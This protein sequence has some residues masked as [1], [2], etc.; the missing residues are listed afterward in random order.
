MTDVASFGG[1]VTIER[2]MYLCDIG[3]KPIDDITTQMI[4]CT[5]SWSAG[6]DGGTSM[7]VDFTM[8]ERLS[9]LAAQNTFVSPEITYR[10]GDGTVRRS[11]LGVYL[12]MLPRKTISTGGVV[13][14]Y[15][16]KDLTWIL[17]NS[18]LTKAQSFPAGTNFGEAIA[19]IC[20][21][22][23]LTNLD[24][25]LTSRTMGAARTFRRGQRRRG[26]ANAL[27]KAISWYNLY[28][29]LDGAMTTL[30][31]RDWSQTAPI[32]IV[33]PKVLIG[34]IQATPSVD[35]VPNT[36]MATMQRNGQAPVVRYAFNTDPESPISLQNIVPAGRRI[37]YEVTDSNV[38]TIADLEALAA[39]TLRDVSSFEM[40]YVCQLK[41]DPSWL[42]IQRTVDLDPAVIRNG[43]PRPGRYHIKAWKVGLTPESAPVELTIGKTVDYV[44]V[45]AA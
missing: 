27:A 31:Y 42:G 19:S 23:G 40:Q 39:K 14:S 38:E 11:R 1:G 37:T 17:Y 21:A 9:P 10:W 30:P 15:T 41:P 20:R 7:K 6:M 34:D 45:A 25:R 43:E 22:A 3:G 36:V 5:V 8:K 29:D 16:G 26:E 44:E 2:R 32:G 12:L 33:S 4:D 35:E 24:I 18:T 28:M 13:A